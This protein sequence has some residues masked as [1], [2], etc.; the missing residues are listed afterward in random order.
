MLMNK[1]DLKKELKEFY[2]AN[3]KRPNI[4]DVP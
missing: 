2:S 4:I 1:L 3:V